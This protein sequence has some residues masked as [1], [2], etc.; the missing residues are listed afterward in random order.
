[1]E[2]SVDAPSMNTLSSPNTMSSASKSQ[3]SQG[4][5]KRQRTSWTDRHTINIIDNCVPCRRCS[6]CSITWSNNTSTG[7]LT[8]HLLEKHHIIAHLSHIVPQV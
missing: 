1:M 3:T 5:S 4:R 7:T 6:H 2:S 8:K